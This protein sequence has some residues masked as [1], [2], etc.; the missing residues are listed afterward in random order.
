MCKL[1]YLERSAYACLLSTLFYASADCQRNI[2]YETFVLF[3]HLLPLCWRYGLESLWECTEFIRPFSHLPLISGH[4]M[5]FTCHYIILFI[6]YSRCWK[7]SSASVLLSLR[8]QWK[9]K[10]FFRLVVLPTQIKANRYPWK[11]WCDSLSWKVIL[12]REINTCNVYIT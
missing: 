8:K 1:P 6:N 11:W 2:V 10:C 5:V 3:D 7:L 4:A 12:Y 9:F